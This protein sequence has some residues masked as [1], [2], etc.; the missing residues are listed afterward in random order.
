MR[1]GVRLAHEIDRLFPP[2]LG[3]PTPKEI[4]DALEIAMS[5]EKIALAQERE[6]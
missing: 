1:D 4:E 5:L 2:E 6:K 3:Y